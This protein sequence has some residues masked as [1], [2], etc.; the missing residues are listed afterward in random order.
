MILAHDGAAQ[1]NVVAFGADSD[2][3]PAH[4][5]PPV[6]ETVHSATTAEVLAFYEGWGPEVRNLLSCAENPSKWSINVVYPP[7]GPEKWARGNVAVLGDAVSIL[8]CC[9]RGK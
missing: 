6:E 2:S 1:I 8:C 9:G 3:D 4:Y 7:L 5:P